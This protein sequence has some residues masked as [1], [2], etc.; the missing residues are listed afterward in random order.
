MT[1]KAEVRVPTIISLHGLCG[2]GKSS[3]FTVMQREHQHLVGG[4]PLL[5]E[6]LAHGCAYVYDRDLAEVREGTTHLVTVLQTNGCGAPYIMGEGIMD[7]PGA[8]ELVATGQYRAVMLLALVPGWMG[9]ARRAWRWQHFANTAEEVE[10]MTEVPALDLVPKFCQQAYE[11]GASPLCVDTQDYP[12]R[13]LT[14]TEGIALCDDSALPTSSAISQ[15]GDYQQGVFIRGQWRGSAEPGEEV[16]ARERLAAVLPEDL[17]GQIVLDIG[18]AQ[19]LFSF[20]ALQ[21]GAAYVVTVETDPRCVA[22]LRGMRS[23]ERLPMAVCDVNAWQEGRCWGTKGPG[24]FPEWQLHGSAVR[25]DLALLLNV[26]HWG[27]NAEQWLAQTLEACECCVI[28]TPFACGQEPRLD[29]QS[30]FPEKPCLPPWWIEQQAEAHGFR[31]ATMQNSPIYP[32]YRL[33]MRLERV[34]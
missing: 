9:E 5:A 2:S 25:Y 33:V 19:G 8:T 4:V 23:L 30:T 21:R 14:P 13:A 12:V 16:A 20:E 31:V 3:L 7:L 28:E 29:P 10:R 11:R 34:A 24:G 32:G 27:H 6:A 17:S 18:A 1:S 22:F 26:L 15:Q